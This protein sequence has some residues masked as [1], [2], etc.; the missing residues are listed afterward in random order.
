[1]EWCRLIGQKKGQNPALSLCLYEHVRAQFT[2]I[3]L[4][5][6]VSTILTVEDLSVSVADAIVFH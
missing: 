5:T 4:S 3:Y 2:V 1:M 6:A